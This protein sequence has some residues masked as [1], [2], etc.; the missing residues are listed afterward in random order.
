MQDL[1]DL[2]LGNSITISPQNSASNEI[3]LFNSFGK[4][5]CF[6]NAAVQALCRL[7]GFSPVLRIQ[8]ER[9]TTLSCLS[10]L[11]TILLNGLY[12]GDVTSLMDMFSKNNAT[13][14]GNQQHDTLEFIE[15]LLDEINEDAFLTS[16]PDVVNIAMKLE[17]MEPESCTLCNHVF[18]YSRSLWS[19]ALELPHAGTE[20]RDLLQ[21]FNTPKLTVPKTCSKCNGHCQFLQS[22]SFLELPS[23]LILQLGRFLDAGEKSDCLVTVP[24]HLELE[25]QNGSTHKYLLRSIIDHRGTSTAGHYVTSVRS[26]STRNW[27]TYD[28]EQVYPIDENNVVTNDA[29]VLIYDSEP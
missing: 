15:L 18:E 20:L 27:K 14:R 13:F 12:P 24:D 21:D 2:H 11:S 5:L 1:L 22:V 16:T 19:L 23:S 8:C 28:D 26:G 29:Y 3:G 9:D 25:M 6:A 10:S 4:N 7:R 17:L